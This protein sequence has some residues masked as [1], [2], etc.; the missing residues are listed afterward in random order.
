MNKL[1]PQHPSVR[2]YKKIANPVLD[3]FG[4]TIQFLTTPDETDESHCVIQGVIPPGGVVPLHSHTGIECFLMLSG[5]QEVLVETDGTYRWT[6][7]SPGDFIQVPS[8][9][10][11]AFRNL[12]DKPAVSLVTTTAVLGRFFQ[13]IG[14]P[15]SA[16]NEPMPPTPEAIQHFIA[17]AIRSGY[18]LATPQ[19]NAAVGLGH[20]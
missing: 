5:E 7:C 20:L 16:N 1:S 18:W 10:K 9:A 14:R 17:T 2:V 19:E 8:E 15:V 12:S 6:L 4:P 11:H 3:V 13:E